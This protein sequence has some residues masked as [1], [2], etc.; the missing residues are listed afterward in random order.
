MSNEGAVR[1]SSILIILKDTLSKKIITQ[2]KHQRQKRESDALLRTIRSELGMVSK[3]RKTTEAQVES[4]RGSLRQLEESC[5][6]KGAEIERLSEQLRNKQSEEM[7]LKSKKRGLK[8][9]L[10]ETEEAKRSLE[11]ELNQSQRTVQEQKTRIKSVI[12]N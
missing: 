11:F 2:I 1:W 3:A 6:V 9:S 12:I 8:V 7:A 10:G 4:L 5:V